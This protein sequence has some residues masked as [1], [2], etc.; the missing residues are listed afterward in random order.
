MPNQ[1]DTVHDDITS[2]LNAKIEEVFN[3][4]DKIIADKR[5]ECEE[6]GIPNVGATYDAFI[7]SIRKKALTQL[8]GIK[9]WLGAH[10]RSMIIQEVRISGIYKLRE[11]KDA[12]T[13]AEAEKQKAIVEKERIIK[14]S[15]MLSDYEK[16][17]LYGHPEFE[18]ST[19]ANRKNKHVKSI[20]STME[21]VSPNIDLVYQK[22]A[23]KQRKS[24]IIGLLVTAVCTFIDFSMIY[25]LF[26]SAN[27]SPAHAITIAIIS[28]AILDA[29]PYVL[30]YTWTK[31]EDD[32]S[33]LELQG[34]AESSE[35]DRKNKGNRILLYAML[36]VII[37]A[38]IVYLI[39][40]ILSFLGGGDFN[41]AFH[42]IIE[43]DWSKIRDVEFSGADFL[44]TVVPLSTSVVALVVGKML[45]SLKTDYIKESIIVI[46]EEINAKIKACEEKII[47]CEKQIKDL[48]D[49]MVTLR[50]EIWTFYLGQKP[51]PSDDNSFRLDVSLAFQKLNL[52]LYEQTYS[53]CCL[54]LRNQA[55]ILLS[56]VNEQLAQ[57]AAN[58]SRVITMGLSKDEE[59]CLND[60]WVIST[61]G[62]DQCSITQS[63]LESI[64]GTVSEIVNALN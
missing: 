10:I 30:G 5:K 20:S 16:Y 45:Y 11:I 6:G 36:I 12:I 58:P 38:F 29:P 22:Y 57:Y 17:S 23:S 34:R 46:N 8:N 18:L 31:S 44:S 15:G 4:F 43:G 41:L 2:A 9:A 27:Y 24:L 56:S 55:N 51:F 3:S 42:A 54:L 14:N 19:K 48:K 35:A 40:R 7:R 28:A 25:A 52:P 21:K 26:L 33:L 13:T 53:D 60:F 50:G 61:N 64:K 37:V 59:Q 1:I 62:E 49:D 63:H 47:D 32:S 39:V